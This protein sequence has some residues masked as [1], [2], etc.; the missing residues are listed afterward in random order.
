MTTPKVLCCVVCRRVT[1]DL[2]IAAHIRTTHLGDN[3]WSKKGQASRIGKPGW[4]LGLTKNDHPALVRQAE[5]WKRTVS[6]NG[7]P[8]VGR[9]HTE[10]A[11][12]K[13]SRSRL[14]LYESGWEPH[15]GRSKKYSYSSPVA[16]DVKVDGRWELAFAEWLDKEKLV[17][18]RNRR[19]FPYTTPK[20]K[21]STYQ[22]DFWVGCWNTYVEIKGYETDLDRAKWA[23]FPCAL[24]VIKKAELIR[25]G[26]L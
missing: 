17:W 1:S 23:Q 11:R 14:L 18:S 6:I 12:Q 13:M 19:R 7:H 3:A 4:S 25:M 8:W 10:D 5:G 16:G 21:R 26:V 22:P 15:C 20:G 9:V 24:R 2:G